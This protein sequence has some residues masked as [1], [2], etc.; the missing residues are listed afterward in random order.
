MRVAAHGTFVANHMHFAYTHCIILI[1]KIWHDFVDKWCCIAL[2]T[3][4]SDVFIVFTSSY[5]WTRKFRP[6]ENIRNWMNFLAII[7]YLDHL[8]GRQSLAPNIKFWQEASESNAIWVN[9]IFIS[10]SQVQSGYSFFLI[11]KLCMI[12]IVP[13][14]PIKH[15]S[16]RSSIWAETYV[17]LRYL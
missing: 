13:F 5:Y 11:W 1:M 4:I 16:V 7:C 8:N 2:R 15:N 12:C 17:M 6:I 10:G 14:I 9:P 3:N